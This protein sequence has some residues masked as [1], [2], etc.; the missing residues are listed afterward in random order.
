MDDLFGAAP[1]RPAWQMAEAPLDRL[2]AYAVDGGNPAPRRREANSAVELYR[3]RA[4]E[5]D[6]RTEL[7]PAVLRPVGMLMLVPPEVVA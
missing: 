6:L 2:A 5:R 1:D 3:R 4:T 7:L